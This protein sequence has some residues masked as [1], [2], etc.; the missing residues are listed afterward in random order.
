MAKCTAV[1]LC[2][3]IYLPDGDEN[4]KF[5]RGAQVEMEK[6]IAEDILAEDARC[7]RDARLTIV[8][9]RRAKRETA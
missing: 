8:V 6:G 1:V 4:K 7:E 5:L 9:K 2:S 3:N